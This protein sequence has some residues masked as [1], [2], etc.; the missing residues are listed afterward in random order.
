VD[1]SDGVLAYI[2]YDGMRSIPGRL[3]LRIED[4]VLRE[5]VVQVIA[6]VDAD[7]DPS[8]AADLASWG[9]ELA[10]GAAR[11]H[12]ELQSE[13]LRAIAALLTYENR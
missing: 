6:E 9:R 5:R 3:P 11:R 4:P 1:L 10:D 13:A 2:G 12:P 8:R 7:A